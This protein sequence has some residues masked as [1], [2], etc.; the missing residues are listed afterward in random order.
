MDIVLIVGDDNSGKSTLVRCLSGLGRG[1]HKHPSDK[2][3]A[4]LNWGNPLHA[5]PT[6]C[7]ISSLNEGNLYNG[8]RIGSLPVPFGAVNTISPHDLDPI[9]TEYQNKLKCSKA[10]LCISTS[11]KVKGWGFGD[12]MQL[13]NNGM[14]G[15]HRVSAILGL[16]TA[17][18]SIP[19]VPYFSLPS[20]PHPRNDVA[21]QARGGIGLQ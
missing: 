11:V 19:S 17:G 1:N 14:I 15:P 18:P 16:G 10:I 12:Y 13:V 4:L 6:L 21:A 9:L 2:N 3:V 8:T 7:L 5:L 20:A